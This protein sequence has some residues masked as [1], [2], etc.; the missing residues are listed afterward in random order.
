[1]T[2]PS[3]QRERLINLALSA[4]SIVFVLL[5]FLIGDWLYSRGQK[6]DPFA[7][8][9]LASNG[10]KL[11]RGDARTGW[12]ELNGGFDGE[13]RYGKLTFRVHTD[14]NGFRSDPRAGA[15]AAPKATRPA[16]LLIGDSFT[17]G[18]GLNWDDTFAAQ[19]AARYGGPVLNAG[20]NSH[21]PTPHLWR[22][23]RWF[24]Q[25]SI[26]A[27]AIV[28]M[29]VDI[30]D[31]FDEATR[32]SD[33]PTTPI[34]RTTAQPQ[35]RPAGET[36]KPAAPLF[37]PQTFQLTHQIYFGLEALVKSFIDDLQVRNNVRSTFIHRPWAEL[38]PAFQPLGVQGGLM[39]LQ[40]K[41]RAAAQLSQAHGHPFYVLIY[42][43][44]AQLAYTNR[45]SWEQ[46]INQ[47]CLKPACSGV[48]DTIPVF[49]DIARRDRQWQRHLYIPG[50][51][52]FNATGN[53]LI[54]QQIVKALK[55][56]EL[57]GVGTSP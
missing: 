48:I 2:S 34:E 28:I 8:K 22:L 40:Q 33:G 23:Q 18:V 24:Q 38:N 17:Y 21:S 14:Q 4:G 25:D 54:A 12:Y 42:P 41:V 47:A 6:R 49:A 5:V 36:A 32:W 53:R 7:L 15:K 46:A 39:R 13:D 56:S 11:Y 1:M 35:G 44:P 3:A 10:V 31:V 43:W 50:D 52:H 16:L 20:V 27:G 19:L 30:S 29:A 26:P 55:R 45:F 57:R 9:P 51:M 37:S